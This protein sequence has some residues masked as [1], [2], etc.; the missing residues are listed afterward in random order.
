MYS[1]TEQMYCLY[2]SVRVSLCCPKSVPVGWS[3]SSQCVHFC[4]MCIVYVVHEAY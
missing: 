2:M 1:K 4:F 3:M